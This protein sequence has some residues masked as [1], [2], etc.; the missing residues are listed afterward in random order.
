M[1]TEARVSL[2]GFVAVAA[3][4]VTLGGWLSA[5]TSDL[6]FE[7]RSEIAGLRGEIAGLRGEMRDDI[8]GVRTEMA[9][10][11]VEMAGLR[12]GQAAL[13]ERMARFEGRLETVVALR[14]D[15]GADEPG[16]PP[17]GGGG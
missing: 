16:A 8:A 13:A 2:G 11:R 4:I 6:R 14:Y 12:E 15:R 10:L 3:L 5:G 9:G 7:M 17:A 1:T